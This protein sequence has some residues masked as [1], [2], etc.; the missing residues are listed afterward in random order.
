MAVN[1]IPLRDYVLVKRVEEKETT[2]GGIII[3]DTAKQKPGEA[4]VIAVGPGR[5]SDKGEVIPLDVKVGDRI[6]LGLYGGH[7]VK[8]DDVEYTLLEEK[9]IWAKLGAAAKAAK[10]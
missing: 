7:D 6:L 3:P 10:R 1:I 8:Y 9:E 4:D 2:K 5:R